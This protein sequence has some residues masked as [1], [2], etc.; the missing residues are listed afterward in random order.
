MPNRLRRGP[1]ICL[2]GREAVVG[3]GPDGISVLD[4]GRYVLRLD[5]ARHIVL[6]FDEDQSHLIGWPAPDLCVVKARLVS[7]A[8]PGRG[9]PQI[10]ERRRSSL[11][12][13]RR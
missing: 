5:E 6:I 4:P 10:S 12:P 13:L 7:Q 3:S 9:A 8:P 1:A 2:F 11:P